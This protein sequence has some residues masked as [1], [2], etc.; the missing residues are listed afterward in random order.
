MPEIST[1]STICC[2]AAAVEVIF[3]LLSVLASTFAAKTAKLK[4]TS[5]NAVILCIKNKMSQTK[6][7]REAQ[8]KALA[9]ALSRNSKTI[10]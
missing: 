4:R 2:L 7:I 3:A 8:G 5:P 6:A 9:A 10:E 1:D